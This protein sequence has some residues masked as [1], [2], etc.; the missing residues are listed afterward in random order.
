MIPIF[1]YGTLREGLYNYDRILKGKTESIVDATIDEYDMLDLGSFP[2]IISGSN[3]IVGE[4]MNIKPNYYLQTLQ[5]LDRLEGYNPSQKSKSLYHREIKK[6]KLVDGKEIDAYVYVYN[7][8]QGINFNEVSS[9][10]W[11]VRKGEES[12]VK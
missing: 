12:S 11:M 10:D 5:L 9:G 3:T 2:G 1:V 6:V 7:T 4:V 8:K